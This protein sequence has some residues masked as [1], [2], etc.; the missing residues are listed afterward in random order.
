[1]NVFTS[2]FQIAMMEANAI[3]P[4]FTFTLKVEEKNH[5][6]EENYVNPIDSII[7]IIKNFL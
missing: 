7:T 4:F 5:G 2:K 1:M 3:I 6:V